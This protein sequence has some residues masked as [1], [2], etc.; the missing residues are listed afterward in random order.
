MYLVFRRSVLT[1]LFIVLTA[2]GAAPAHED[3]Y[4]SGTKPIGLLLAHDRAKHPA[5][6]VVEPLRHAAQEK[7]GYHTLSLQMPND[8][9]GFD[10]YADKFPRAY[11][12]FNAGID[13][14]HKLGVTRIYLMGHSM[15]A[16]MAS[17]FVASHP[18]A[19]IAGL[20]VAGCR[21][22]G[23]APLVCDD[24]LRHVDKNLAV[25]D[26]WG[27][28]NGKDRKAGK[29]RSDLKSE[30]YTQIAI[31]GGDHAFTDVE[32]KFLAAVI[33]WLQQRTATTSALISQ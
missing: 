10:A 1:F 31:P 32:D 7:L 18:E 16:R 15:G 28:D 4:L 22:G 6:K 25:L 13:R 33:Q 14:L 5:W 2:C 23:D 8:D 27:E 26:I 17:A 24:N 30:A 12:I 9:I 20:I 3:L 21:N 11:E 29:Q 19:P